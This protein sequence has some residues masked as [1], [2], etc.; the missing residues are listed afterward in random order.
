MPDTAQSLALEEATLTNEIAQDRAEVARLEA[1]AANIQ[2][3][4]AKLQELVKKP[5]PA[6][7]YTPTVTPAIPVTPT[8]V[9]VVEEKK[10]PYTTYALIGGGILAAIGIAIAAGKKKKE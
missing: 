2:A 10:P 6:P 3:E 1:Q 9:P 7:V 5:A 8:Y 4:I